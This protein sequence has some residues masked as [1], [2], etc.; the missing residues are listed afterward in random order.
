MKGKLYALWFMPFAVLQIVYGQDIQEPNWITNGPVF[1]VTQNSTNVYVGGYFNLVGRPTGNGV[2]YNSATGE[3]IVSGNYPDG[4]ISSSASD[5]QGGFFIAGTNSN[6]N[7]Q[8]S[9]SK[10]GT[11]IRDGLAHILPDGEVSSTFNPVLAFGR[12]GKIVLAATTDRV[13]VGTKGIHPVTKTQILKIYC[14][15]FDGSIQWERNMTGGEAHSAVIHEGTVYVVGRFTGIEGQS[16]QRAAAIDLATGSLLA[17]NT[18]SRIPTLNSSLR[19]S[20]W[21]GVSGDEVFI[22]YLTPPGNGGQHLFSADRLTGAPTGW[23]T[24]HINGGPMIVHNGRVYYTWGNTLNIIDAVT[25]NPLPVPSTVV[26]NSTMSSLSAEGENIF[27]A[28][29]GFNDSNGNP[30]G[31]VFGFNENSLEVQIM[32]TQMYQAID[33]YQSNSIM[34]LSAGGGRMF[35]GG[36]FPSIGMRRVTN[37]FGY[38]RQSEEWIDFA[39]TLDGDV[40]N[41]E[42][43]ENK[44]YVN[45]YFTEIDGQPRADVACFDLT[46]GQLTPW[47]INAVVNDFARWNDRLYVAGE[48]P[49]MR[50]Y[51]GDTEQPIAWTAQAPNIAGTCTADDNGVYTAGSDGNIHLLDHNT[52]DALHPPVP[53]GGYQIAGMVTSNNRLF[54]AG[55]FNSLGSGANVVEDKYFGV[56][57]LDTG[58][59]IESNITISPDADWAAPIAISSD[60]G[61]VYIGGQFQ[62]VNGFSRNKTAAINAETLQPTDWTIPIESDLDNW[63][64]PVSSISAFEDGVYISGHFSRAKS[65]PAKNLTVSSP[66]RS[67]VV[68]GTVFLDNNGNGTQDAGEPGIPN[69]LMEVRPGNLFYPTDANGHYTLYTGIGNYSIEPVHP[70]YAL[71][72]TPGTIDVSFGDYLMNSQN[73]NFA[74]VPYPSLTNDQI[75]IIS[76][77]APRPG[78][79][80]EYS[81]SYRNGGTLSSSGVV[82]VTVDPRLLIESTVPPASNTNGNILEWSYINLAPGTSAHITINARVPAPTI[83]GSLLGEHIITTAAIAPAVAD[84][85]ESNNVASLDEVVVG[86]VDPNDKLVTPQGYGPNGYID[87][88]T[89]RLTYTIRFQNVGTAPAENIFLQDQFDLNLDVSTFSVV[90]S[91]HPNFNFYIENRI[92]HVSYLNINLEDSVSNEPASH[93]FFT[94]SI[95]LN[96]GLARGTVIQN[97]ASI[98]FDYNL[99]LATNTVTNTLRNPPYPVMIFTGQAEASLGDEISLPVMVNRFEN[100]LGGQ[101]S[102]SWDPAVITFEDVEAFTLPGLTVNSFG[103]DHTA[104]GYLTF[105]W[106]DPGI[107]TQT[108]SDSTAIFSIRFTLT[109]NPGAESLVSISQFPTTIEFVG[110]NYIVMESERADGRIVINNE[111][112]IVGQVRYPNGEAVQNV[113]ID[114]SGSGSATTTTDATGSYELRVEPP[115]AQATYTLTPVKNDDPD[116]LNGI[117]VQDVAIVRRHI[118]QTELLTSPYAIIAADVSDNQIISIQDILILQAVILGVETNYP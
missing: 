108:L 112:D 107:Q 94:F 15:G 65:S 52:G 40:Q 117:D 5:G 72:M 100:V 25:K 28:G 80:Y 118:L 18:G 96:H 1:A 89:D 83:A 95:G 66:D 54:V 39:P 8:P 45:G 99:P 17:W 115:N 114:I 64:F 90:E 78:F 47:H 104:D 56:I 9:F 30:I 58:L 33:S 116:L 87:E 82:S 84:N 2:L 75:E 57:D 62:R 88:D 51:N 31:S 53:Y 93:G 102:V 97:S 13:I 4:I 36:G 98:V 71:S 12:S 49:G 111:I 79:E 29:Q 103:L 77:R 48:N 42:A 92:L 61:S 113:T 86:S 32:N 70:T 69:I 110:E 34:T 22:R 46:T 67:N 6:W 19:R 68:S 27:V 21:I 81:V 3:P 41:L 14:L 59:P 37:L 101:F 55:E 105:A 50:A 20:I 10:V 7:H 76:D 43:F 73:N 109:G 60:R 85:D 38:N 106:N 44:L 63:S 24:G 16:R 23:G 74:V 11:Q 26:Y 35:I 91:S